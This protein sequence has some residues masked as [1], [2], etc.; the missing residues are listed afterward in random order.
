LFRFVVFVLMHYLHAHLTA[1]VLVYCSRGSP[2][3]RAT[4][5]VAKF[6]SVSKLFVVYL[7]VFLMQK[8]YPSQVFAG[9]ASMVCSSLVS[10]CEEGQL[11]LSLGAAGTVLWLYDCMMAGSPRHPSLG[12][13][14]FGWC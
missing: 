11:L 1:G 4:L 2:L 7:V 3:G 13:R 14:F 8:W 5:Q 12:V 6:C 10:G 9:L